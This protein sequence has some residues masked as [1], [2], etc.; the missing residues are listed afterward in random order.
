M[1]SEQFQE[2]KSNPTTVE[3]FKELEKVRDDI[4]DAL[5]SGQTLN[6]SSSE[7]ISNT[8]RLIGNLEGINQLLNINYE[9]EAEEGR[10]E[11]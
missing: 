11:K 8:A 2:W 3:I 4:K 9:D 6:S 7:T 10:S 5:C 1:N